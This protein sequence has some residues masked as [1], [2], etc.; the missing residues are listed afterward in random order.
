MYTIDSD[1]HLRL[2]RLVLSGF[3]GADEAHAF[4]REQQ[5]EVRKL[6]PPYGS[7]LT[8]ADVGNLSVQSQTVSATLRELVVH[9]TFVSRRLA[10]IGGEGLALIQVKRIANR[11]EMRLFTSSVDA[12]QWLLS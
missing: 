11:S 4:A 7:H 12:E 10:L 8:L 2:I 6:G 5:A 9:A 3:W 1:P